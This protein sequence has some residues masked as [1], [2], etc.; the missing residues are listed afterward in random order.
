MFHFFLF[1]ICCT[2]TSVSTFRTVIKSL[3]AIFTSLEG[4]YCSGGYSFAGSYVYLIIINFFSLSAIL[5][6]LFT[7]LDVFHHEFTE[8]QVPAHGLF[9]CVKGPIMANFYIGEVL[10]TL[11]A[12]VGVIH[13]TSGNPETGAIAWPTEAVENGIEVI[14]YCVVMTVS[15]FMMLRYFGNNDPDFDTNAPKLTVKQALFDAYVSYIPEFVSRVSGCCTDAK[16][17]RKKRRDLKLLKK[18]STVSPEKYTYCDV[19]K[20]E[21]Q[22]GPIP[23]TS[24]TNIPPMT[25][26]TVSRDD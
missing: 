7:Y 19:S 4:R 15:A 17:L 25:Q 18:N 23:A 20:V 5:T 21:S 22:P 3:I 14:I 13:G 2:N 9:W 8:L 24:N 26:P 12:T 10:V 16:G 1:L 6:A 11:L